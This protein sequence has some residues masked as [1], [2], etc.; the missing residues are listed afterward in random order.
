MLVD[1]SALGRASVYLVMYHVYIIRS[2]KTGKFYTGFTNDLSRR[3]A[4]HDRGTSSTPSTRGK[5][6]FELLHGELVKNATEA[7]A[8]EK[9]L[10]SGQGRKWRDEFLKNK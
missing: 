6:P 2:K 7:R 10:K 4:E 9:F 8:R 3:L 1:L 5:G